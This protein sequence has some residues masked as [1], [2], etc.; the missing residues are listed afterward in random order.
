MKLWNFFGYLYSY[1]MWLRT[2]DVGD[3]VSEMK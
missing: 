3:H 1:V 2:P